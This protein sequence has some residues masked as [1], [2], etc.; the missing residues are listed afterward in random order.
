[1]NLFE[2]AKLHNQFSQLKTIFAEIEK[3]GL[4]SRHQEVW[5]NSPLNL[6]L[7]QSFD[8]LST[9]VELTTYGLNTLK[10]IENEKEVD[11]LLNTVINSQHFKHH[12]SNTVGLALTSN[13]A[14]FEVEGERYISID[15]NYM[16]QPEQKHHLTGSTHL[17]KIHAGSNVTLVY[18]DHDNHISPMTSFDQLYLFIE[19]GAQ[20]ELVVKSHLALQHNGFKNIFISLA[21]NAQLNFVQINQYSHYHR[22]DLAIELKG[23]NAEAQIYGLN[24][25]DKEAHNDLQSLVVH[26]VGDNQSHQLIKTTASD[27]AR[28]SFTG[29]I[30]IVKDAQRVNASQMSRNLIIGEKAQIQSQPQLAIYADDVKCAHGSSTGRMSQ[31]ELFYLTSRG[32]EEQHARALLNR[33]FVMDIVQKIK[34]PQA[35]ANIL[36]ALEI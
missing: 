27:H 18:S 22:T 7:N 30:N 31:E 12:F 11:G 25:C 9:P 21:E 32:I 16:S 2:L 8:Y 24:L 34:H 17:F 23:K 4:P 1:M 19:A 6:K 20:V 14:A 28:S 5:R 15:K 35:Q 10:Q 36:G 29:K 33:G 26:H 3:L 13:L